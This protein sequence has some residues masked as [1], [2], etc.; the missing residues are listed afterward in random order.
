MLACLVKLPSALRKGNTCFYSG[1]N[2]CILSTC[3][4]NWG[5]STYQLLQCPEQ[6]RQTCSSQI[7][8]NWS[9]H[10]STCI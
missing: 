8:T 10:S 4:G 1:F 7:Q 2:H 9:K 3:F 6:T 5:K